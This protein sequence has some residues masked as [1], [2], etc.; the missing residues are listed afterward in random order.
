MVMP[1]M[2]RC[3]SARSTPRSA[4]VFG[5]R[6]GIPCQ[7]GRIADLH[8]PRLPRRGA[9]HCAHRCATAPPRLTSKRPG[10]PPSCRARFA[11]DSKSRQIDRRM[12]ALEPTTNLTTTTP[13]LPE[14][15][16]SAGCFS[17]PSSE[18][19]SGRGAQRNDRGRTRNEAGLRKL[20]AILH[21]DGVA[22]GALI[23]RLGS[24]GQLSPNS[25]HHG[26]CEPPTARRMRDSGVGDASPK[27]GD[28][29][30]T[31]G[32]IILRAQARF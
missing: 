15:R 5:Q 18:P 1:W 21:I 20:I 10:P 31:T 14:Q 12:S 2:K 11:A 30:E 25:R 23:G 9:A 29:C 28:V 13:I 6:S 26:G 3:T 22:V 32:E 19:S 16:R 7:I 17:Y 27:T 24:T 8:S 4:F